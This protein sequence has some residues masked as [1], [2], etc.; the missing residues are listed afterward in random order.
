MWRF[1]KM[2]ASYPVEVHLGYGREDR[3]ANS[4]RMM[5]EALEPQSVHVVAGGHEWPAWSKLWA[6]FL[7][8]QFVQHN[9]RAASHG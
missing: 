5:A 7:D 6:D 4:H 2:R 9:T 1:I 8:R 3:F